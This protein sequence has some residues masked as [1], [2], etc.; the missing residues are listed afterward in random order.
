MSLLSQLLP[1]IV[2]Q[3]ATLQERQ[4]NAIS[5][6][7]LLNDTYVNTSEPMGNP[8]P[9]DIVEVINSNTEKGVENR[10]LID[11]NVTNI[12]NNGVTI[13]SHTSLI[14]NNAAGIGVNVADIAAL[15]AKLNAF[16][17]EGVAF[18]PSGFSTVI[19]S[20]AT[21]PITV[22]A[23]TPI[24]APVVPSWFTSTA[25]SID[26]DV[27]IYKWEFTMNL[28]A[29]TNF[30]QIYNCKLLPQYNSTLF[31]GNLGFQNTCGR[32]NA[33]ATNPFFA[34]TTTISRLAGAGTV[35]FDTE[36]SHQSGAV[37]GINWSWAITVW[38]LF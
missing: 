25:T 7:R 11:L 17:T 15:E 24:G 18:G 29:G 6:I 13:N 35:T 34:Y 26:L 30:D 8:A 28:A 16:H 4:R 10:S 33:G 9:Q 14:T 27:G 36:V 1:L 38:K 12:A 5:F 3:G 20:V 2:F 23:I 19:G 32:T 31:V 37:P 22:T 21:V